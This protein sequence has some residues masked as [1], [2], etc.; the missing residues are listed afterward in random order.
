MSCHS[1]V[2]NAGQKFARARKRG[3]T[4]R[5]LEELRA[6]LKNRRGGESATGDS[7]AVI[8]ARIADA[9]RVQQAYH[10]RYSSW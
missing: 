7:Q 10:S 4:G 3:V 8:H 1:S 9:N 5:A 2:P 6:A